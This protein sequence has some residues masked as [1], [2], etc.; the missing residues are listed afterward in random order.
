MKNSKWK[1]YFDKYTQLKMIKEWDKQGLCELYF[2][3]E[4]GDFHSIQIFLT[5][6]HL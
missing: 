3:D 1:N 2:Y 4:S 6:G 5:D